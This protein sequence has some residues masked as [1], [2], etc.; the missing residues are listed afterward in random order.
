M[1]QKTNYVWEEIEGDGSRKEDNRKKE[2][3]TRKNIK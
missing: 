2:G 3:E 1:R